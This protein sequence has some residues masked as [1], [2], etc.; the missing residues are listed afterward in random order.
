MTREQHH[1]RKVMG[2][3]P[4]G[5]TVVT[6]RG[7]DASPCG[8]TANSIASVSLDPPLVLVCVDRSASSHACIT[9][10]GSFA[11]S[12]LSSQDEELARRFAKG[13]FAERF[14]DVSFTDSE[15]GSPVLT[16]ALAWLDCRVANVYEAGDHSIVI[17][18]VISC[19][20]REGEPLV[21]FRGGYHRIPV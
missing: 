21:F 6:S 20:A 4:T 1:F 7:P 3:F 10:G 16:G 2:N 19:D 12:V 14:R 9:Q 15:N 5:V 8:L 13:S 17:G 11:I 18:E